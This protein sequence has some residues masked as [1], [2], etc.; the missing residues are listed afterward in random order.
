MA[1]RHNGAQS[2]EEQVRAL[3]EEAES[4]AAKAFEEFVGKPSF[5]RLLALSA[6]NV[7][8]VTRIGFDAM[9]LLW[10]N[11]R[12]AGRADIVRLSRQLHRNEDKLERVLQEVEGL[13][14][15]LTRD[16]QDGKRD[17]PNE[18]TRGRSEQTH[19]RNEQE[20]RS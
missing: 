9:D 20:T 10:R 5:G 4:T 16:R 14:D 3:F 8:A 19:E 11:A 1:D 15:E 7:A 2:P 13:R 6:E 12:V 17:L 18:L